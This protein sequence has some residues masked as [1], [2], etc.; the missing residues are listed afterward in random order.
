MFPFDNPEHIGKPLVFWCLQGDQKGTL[1]RKGLIS[2]KNF[3][4]ISYLVIPCHMCL[5]HTLHHNV[6]EK[7][8]MLKK[9]TNYSKKSWRC[10]KNVND[11]KAL[12]SL[13]EKGS[14]NWNKA[15]T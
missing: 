9:I 1:G 3:V 5:S 15:D 12:P 2:W 7:P 13:L 11:N 8:W 6:E 14:I 10:Q 4:H